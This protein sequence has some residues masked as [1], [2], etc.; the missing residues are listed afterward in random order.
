[1]RILLLD[2]ELVHCRSLHVF[3]DNFS[4]EELKQYSEKS[5]GQNETIK[6]A[7]GHRMEAEDIEICRLRT[8][9]ALATETVKL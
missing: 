7:K 6:G 9:T 2:K 1:M 8:N 4:F 3:E 5:K